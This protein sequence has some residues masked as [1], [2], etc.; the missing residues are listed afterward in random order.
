[1]NE[2]NN[3]VLMEA[4][5]NLILHAGDARNC[6]TKALEKAKEFNFIEAEIQMNEAEIELTK[7]HK[8][9][10]EIIQNETRGIHYPHSLLFAHAQDTLMT[11]ISEIR[12]SKELVEVLKII[13][14]GKNSE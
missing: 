4:A 9:Q 14:R 11:I 13:E 2:F 7:A 5:M 8:A 10:T 6:C 12:F 3:E 1:M